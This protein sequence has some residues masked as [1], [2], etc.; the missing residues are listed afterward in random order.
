MPPVYS[1]DRIS[2]TDILQSPYLEHAQETVEELHDIR[3]KERK[4]KKQQEKNTQKEASNFSE[5]A[6][7]GRYSRVAR[8]AKLQ[9][10]KK[11]IPEQRKLRSH[12]LG[13]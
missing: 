7:L 10:R 2:A 4:G 3:R 9:T 13:R 6:R 12:K 5:G 8:A 1:N 11:E